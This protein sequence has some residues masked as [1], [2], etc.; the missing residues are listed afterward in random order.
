MHTK[1]NNHIRKTLFKSVCGGMGLFF[2]LGAGNALVSYAQEKRAYDTSKYYTV[3]TVTLSDGT[4]VERIDING[5]PVPPPGFEIERLKASLPKPHIAA[6]INTLTVPAFNWVFGCSAVSGAMI[7]GYYDRQGWSDIYTGPTNGGVMPLNNSSWPTWSDGV[8]T[9][10]SCP[11]IAS[12]NGVDGRSTRGSIDDYWVEYLSTSDDPYITNGWTQHTW[13]EAIGDYMKTSQSAFGNVDGSTRFFYWINSSTPLTCDDMESYAFPDGTLGRK[14]FYEARGY[15][16]TDCYNQRT[17]NIITGGFSFTQFKNEIDQG[18]PVMLNLAGHTVVGIGYDDS[19]NLVYIHDTWDYDNHTMTWGDSYS[20]MELQSVSIVNLQGCA[21]TTPDAFTFTDQTDVELS[22]V[23]TSNQITVSGICA[24]ASISISGGTYSI[25]GGGYTGSSGTVSN[26]DT[27]TVRQTSSSSYSTTTDAVLT[28]GGVSD[29]FS[30]TTKAC[31]DT[32]PDTF[33]F[34][35][36]TDVELSTVTT[37]NQITV[38]GICASASISI[39]GGT[40]SINGGG[41]TGSSGTVSNGDTVTVRQTSSSSYSTTT[42]AELTIGG[43]SDTFSVTTK[44]CTDSTPDAFTFTDQTDVELSTVTTSNQVT[45]SGICL[46]ASIS[47]TGGT[48]SVNGGG[49]TASSGTVNNGD[50][51]T[52]RQTSS[53]SYS[54]TTNAILTIGGVSDTYSVKTILDSDSF[55]WK[56]ILPAIIN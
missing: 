14:L 24:S 40:Y 41:Y 4:R 9:Y 10:P 29:T 31:T 6:G 35:D 33:T 32:T 26:G 20:G 21:D 38:S 52:V 17:D 55:P 23:M 39:S 19:T 12:Q 45:V 50:T 51:V 36:Q 22:T 43:V 34:T 18:R 27:V 37:S 7:A 16:V 44:A 49:Y 28:I 13:G 1:L 54:T 3:T 5:P 25:N 15:T 48:Y 42:N 30:V 11:L 47:I 46:S 2:I 56:V 8:K 53:S